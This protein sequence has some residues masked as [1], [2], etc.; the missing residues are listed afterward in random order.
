[1]RSVA[2]KVGFF[3]QGVGWLEASRG[4]QYPLTEE[5]ILKSYKVIS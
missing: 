4:A 3:A 2:S 5:F 1:M